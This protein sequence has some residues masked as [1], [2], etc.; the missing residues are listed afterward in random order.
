M[1]DK[2]KKGTGLSRREF[3]RDAGVVLGGTALGSMALING[4]CKGEAAVITTTANTTT[5][6]THTATEPSDETSSSS[7]VWGRKKYPFPANAAYIDIDDM[8][9]L[10]CGLCMDACSMKHFGIINPE[11]SRIQVHT[12]TLPL[13][14]AFAS[15][16][17]H[18]EQHDRECEKACPI[19]P[20]VI[21]YDDKTLHM[22]VDDAR[23]IGCGL[24]AAACPSNAVRLTKKVN[25][26]SFTCD[27]CDPD[28]TG[29]IDPECIKICP[30]NAPLLRNATYFRVQYRR[31]LEQRAEQ[32][33]KRMYPLEKSL[34]YPERSA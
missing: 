18:C 25:G 4:S 7:E 19:D 32:F 11:L 13:P 15:T 9:C 29:E 23:C 10:G 26:K 8:N 1:T 31:S 33:A 14:K 30:N 20:P 22:V 2:Q 12:F 27:L 24:C 21:Y 5:T 17:T 28:N 16:C 6:V 34:F 3:L